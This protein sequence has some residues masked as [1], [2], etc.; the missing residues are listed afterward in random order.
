MNSEWVSSVLSPKTIA[1]IIGINYDVGSIKECVLLRSYVN[2]VY[3]VTS[4]SNKF[5]FKLYREGWRT[6]ENILFEIDFLAHVSKHGVHVSLP[7]RAIDGEFIHSLDAPEG[8]RFYVLYDYA[9]GGKP[10]RPFTDSLYRRVG[11]ELAKL[12]NASITFQSVH[13][14]FG[15]NTVNMLEKPLAYIKSYMLDRQDDWL[16]LQDVSSKAKEKLSAL[17]KDM[18]MGV[19]HGDMSLD[20]LNVTDNGIITFYDFDACGYGYLSF[21]LL[22]AYSVGK[23]YDKERLWQAQLQGY[24]SFK[25]VSASDLEALPYLRILYDIWI[26]GNNATIWAKT[27]GLW[28]IS[29]EHLDTCL[30]DLKRWVTLLC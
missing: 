16:F 5:V 14:R 10:Q 29:G 21:D 2:D 18:S 13:E 8:L 30:C 26:I 25:G 11:E 15:L 20:N 7:V 19:C 24:M 6:K 12:H 17:D 9:R 27:S 4:D 28:R 23:L 3:K 1:D 22:G